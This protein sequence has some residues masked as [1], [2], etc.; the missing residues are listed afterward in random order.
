M[1]ISTQIE[2][3]T[4]A[5]NKIRTKLV[6]LG[7]S[8]GTAKLEDCA[9]AVDAIVNKGAVTAE[10]KEGE[11]YTIPAGYHNGA[12]T[13]SGVAGGGNYVL[14]SK[15]VTPSKEQQAVT[16]DE[17]KYGLSDVIVAPIPDEYQDVSDVNATA[18]DVLS[19]KIIVTSDGTVTAGTMINHGAVNATM[20][21]LSV[22]SYTIPAGYHNG[23]GTVTL[24]GDIETALAA[25]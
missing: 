9:D 3:I 8:N 5:R 1:S 15:A 7:L 25:I 24:T 23:E 10:V 14:Q 19:P 18:A 13:V 6:A 22:T 21:G 12:G 2:K 11:S 16:P 20:D 17:G 4:N